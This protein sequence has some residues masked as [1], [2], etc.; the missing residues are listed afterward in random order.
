MI[1]SPVCIFINM[2]K[3]LLKHQNRQYLIRPAGTL[4]LRLQ[5]VKELFDFI[6]WNGPKILQFYVSNW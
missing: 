1:F 5:D 6:V 2:V 4:Y 3:L